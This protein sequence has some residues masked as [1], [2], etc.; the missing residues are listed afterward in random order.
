MNIAIYHNLPSGGGKRAL[1]EMTRR[2]AQRHDVHVYSL[3]AA[4]H[5]FCDLR[6]YCRQHIV[7][8]F[9][10][11]SLVRRPF[12]RLNQ[13][14]R[15]LDLLRL[16]GLQGWIA[17][18]ID[19]AGH[20]VAF[21]HNCQ[22]GQSPSVLRYLRTPAVY[23]CQEPPRQIY[24]PTISRPYRRFSTVQQLGN[25]IDPLPGLYRKLLASL[26]RQNVRTA[27]LVLVNSAYS[28][29]SL[30]RVYGIFARV[31]YLGVDTGN[32]RPLGLPKEDF[33]LSV[34]ALSPRKGFDFLIQSLALLNPAQRPRLVITSNYIDGLER[35]YLTQLA[36]RLQVEIELQERITDVQLLA[37]YNRARVTV[38]TPVMEPFGFVPLESMACGTPV[39]GVREAGVRESV[40]NGI[41]GVLTERDPQAF[42][43]ALSQ[44]LAEPAQAETL[45]QNGL[46]HVREAWTWEACVEELEASLRV[47]V[48]HN[49][50]RGAGND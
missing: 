26:D 48:Q 23:Y 46:R 34:G 18:Q 32:F 28:R 49:P 12:G 39:V 20:D 1:H 15:S 36:Q 11:L 7:Y 35:Q 42:A 41:T 44:F 30:Y 13:G 9:M 24:E 33:V 17:A 40:T 50:M 47:V 14:I 43:V 3:S 22:Y 25:V 27:R 21:V 4:E 16:R 37:L 6:P 10:P 29:E 5:D 38:Y 19:A 8:P 31:C 2:L 45:G